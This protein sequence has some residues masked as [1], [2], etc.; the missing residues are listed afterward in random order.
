MM[1]SQMPSNDLI[2]SHELYKTETAAIIPDMTE[3]RG[4]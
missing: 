3:E 4:L 2:G 1:S